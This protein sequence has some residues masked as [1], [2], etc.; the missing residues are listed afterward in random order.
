MLKAGDLRKQH[1]H[2]FYSMEQER[3]PEIEGTVPLESFLPVEELK[4][5]AYAG[6]Y[7]KGEEKELKVG[8]LRNLLGE[9]WYENLRQ[10][11]T[12]D[13]CYYT[14]FTDPAGN[15][16]IAAIGKNFQFKALFRHDET[17]PPGNETCTSINKLCPRCT[18]FGLADKTDQGDNGAVGYAGRFRASTLLSRVKLTET[19]VPGNIPAKAT[20]MAQPVQFSVWRDSNQEV[21]R[22]FALPIMGAPKPSKRDMNGYFNETTGNLKGAKRYHHADTNFDKSLPGI[23]AHTDDKRN[24]EENLD[25][26]QHMRPVAAVCREGVEFSGVVGGENCTSQEIAALLMLLDR[27]SADHA[28]KLGL[29]KSIGLG[30]VSSRIGRV[31]VRRADTYEWR[32]VEIPQGGARQDLVSVIRELLPEA[33]KELNVLINDPALLKQVHSPKD[34]KARLEFTKAGLKYWQDAHVETV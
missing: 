27:R 9:P 18:L 24:T 3:H 31:W 4:K 16:R 1:Y 26:G 28:F 5:I 25:Y 33:V 15:K 29:G 6:V 20:L 7:C 12:G 32:S 17:I 30:S 34:K 13:W 22:Q 10:L 19:K 11:Q 14:L 8:R 2:R 21:I 23:V